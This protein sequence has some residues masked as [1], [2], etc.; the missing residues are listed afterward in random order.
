ML[1]ITIQ[2]KAEDLN[3]VKA[4]LSVIRNNIPVM[5]VKKIP[6]YTHEGVGSQHTIKIEYNGEG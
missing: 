2:I 5:L 4:H 3:D 6:D 1:D